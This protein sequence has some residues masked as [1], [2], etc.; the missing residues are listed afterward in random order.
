MVS[1]ISYLC[2]TDVMSST[3]SMKTAY[4][5]WKQTALHLLQHVSQSKATYYSVFVFKKM[6]IDN[7]SKQIF[8]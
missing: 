6:Y 1:F 7:V 5:N 3:P 8:P 2:C 4:K